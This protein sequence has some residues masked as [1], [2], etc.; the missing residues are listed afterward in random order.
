MNE[1]CDTPR[2]IHIHV[3]YGGAH[4]WDEETS[5]IDIASYWPDVSGLRDIEE[6]LVAWADTY[7]WDAFHRRGRI[8]AVKIARALAPKGI[9]VF[10]E[11]D[12]APLTGMEE[13][14]PEPA[15]FVF[16]WSRCW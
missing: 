1:A 2:E 13:I 3:D 15:P 6:E 16:A 10:F 5:V 14:K 9:P 4:A 8:I 12:E 7:D 11:R